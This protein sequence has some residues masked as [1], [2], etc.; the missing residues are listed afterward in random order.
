VREPCAYEDPCRTVPALPPSYADWP[1]L[2]QAITA[3]AAIE[4]QVQDLLSHMTL[5]QKVGQMVQGEIASTSPSD[6]AASALGSMLNAGGSW[7]GGARHAAVADWLA[8]A[9]RYWDGSPTVN[10]TRIPVLW[11]I[12]AVHGQ[13]AVY[14]ATVFP[15]NIGQGATHDACLVEEIG[16]ATAAQ[17]RATGQDWTFGPT[18]AVPR[19]DR[20]GRTYEGYSED[21]AVV[22]WYG[23]HAFR[24][25]GDLDPD[26]RRLRG[27]LATAKHFIGDGGT[28]SGTDQGVTDCPERELVNVHG[29]GYLGALGPGGG[30]TVMASYSSWNDRTGAHAPEGK[31]HGSAYLVH[32]VLKAKMGFDGLVVSDYDGIA[33]VAGCTAEDCPRAVNAGIDLFMFSGRSWV[34]FI[35]N[36]M[37]ETRLRSDDPRYIPLARIDD[38]VSRIL[39]VKARAGLL[40]GRA[41]K[42]SARK[43]AGAGGLLHRDLARRAV[44]ESLVL[45]KN[46]GQVLPLPLPGAKRV[47][48]VGNGMDSFATQLG[49]WTISW[50]GSDVT[51]ADVPAGAGDT[52]LAG[53]KAAVGA[54]K[55]DAYVTAA[56]VPGA[57]DYGRYS[58]VIAVV[59]ETPY[60][61]GHGDIDGS[62]TL[63]RQ[64]R[65]PQAEVQ[66]LLGKVRGHGVPVVTVLLSGR[67]LW[68]NRE[69]DA[70]AA[71]VAAFLPGTEGAG[72]ADVL[73]RK[74]DGTVNHEFT[75]RLSYSWPRSDCQTPLNLGDPGYDPLFPVGYGLTSASVATLGALGESASAGGCGP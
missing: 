61:E 39:R 38:A 3:D 56:E 52:I 15:H 59:G 11:G 20:W 72:V 33:Q 23:E 10:G 51:N 69:L 54:A 5:A 8:L 41:V 68:V 43:G 9:D 74:A 13:G 36:T 55:V 35:Q 7:P 16:A 63:G 14:G 60:A 42:P 47:L 44:R 67:P 21:P 73:F 26:G 40:D 18:L 31:V 49:G 57:L 70:S 50:Q 32:D 46:D 71:F 30:Q 53:I 65:Y 2:E 6:V 24:A 34:Q 1:R 64:P 28:R 66:A 17:V 27:I 58:A 62:G 22:R 19:D 25:L 29:Q 37:A 45:L 4:A 12:D 48:V 75:G